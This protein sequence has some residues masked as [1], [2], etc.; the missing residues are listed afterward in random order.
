MWQL[1][2]YNHNSLSPKTST[3]CIQAGTSSSTC[4]CQHRTILL[5][6]FR[7]RDVPVCHMSRV[8]LRDTML[9]PKCFVSTAQLYKLTSVTKVSISVRTH[10]KPCQRRRHCQQNASFCINLETCQMT[11]ITELFL[12]ASHIIADRYIGFLTCFIVRSNQF[13]I[14]VV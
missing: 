9:L 3:Y 4:S 2:Q 8:L 1:I 11:L 13:I 6:R 10:L 5:I 14:Y 12:L 7:H